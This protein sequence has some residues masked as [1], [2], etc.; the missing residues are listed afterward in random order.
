[1]LFRS[2]DAK[3]NTLTGKATNK[4][5]Y[6]DVFLWDDK[7]EK[8]KYNG[9]TMSQVG[10]K[11][12]YSLMDFEIKYH[13]FTNGYKLKDYGSYGPNDNDTHTIFRAYESKSSGTGTVTVKDRFGNEYSQTVTW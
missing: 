11:D 1:M 2:Y 10:Y 3:T 6:V 4:Y 5:I 8:P 7:W 9:V 13:Y 12:A